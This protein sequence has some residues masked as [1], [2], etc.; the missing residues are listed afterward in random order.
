MTTRKE[1]VFVIVKTSWKSQNIPF[2]IFYSEEAAKKHIKELKT[3]S[4]LF[5]ED[6]FDIYKA[7]IYKDE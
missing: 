3:S 7:V 5:Y 6:D 4:T 1:W 2:A